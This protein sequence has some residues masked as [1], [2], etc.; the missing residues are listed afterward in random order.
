[1]I[2][3]TAATGNNNRRGATKAEN[4]LLP[5]AYRDRNKGKEEGKGIFN[6][7]STEPRDFIE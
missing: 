5:V 4:F 3:F 2:F 7:K 1:M 6:M